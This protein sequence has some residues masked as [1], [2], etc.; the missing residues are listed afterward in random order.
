MSAPRCREGIRALASGW[1]PYG[2]NPWAR[3][4]SLWGRMKSSFLGLPL[5]VRLLLVVQAALYLAV[6]LAGRLPGEE[7]VTL[8]ASAVTSGRVWTLLTHMP[9]HFRSDA[10]GFLFD[11]SVLWSLGGIFGRRWRQTHFLF[12]YGTAGVVGGLAHVGAGLLW[13]AGCGVPYL[14][15]EA[16]SFAL[17]TAF[18]VVFGETPVSMFG[19]PPFK[20]KWVFFGL[21]A[22][23]VVLFVSG[24]NP[25]FFVQAGGTLGG[26]LM[27]TGRWRPGKLRAWLDG[28]ARKRE[29][30]RFRVLH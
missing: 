12:F 17:L 13:P 5:V 27:L 1:T 8:S 18:W 2:P 3:R 23:E 16:S 10:F 6:V 24:N 15:S 9:F 22:L 28:L 7:Y 20:G 14:G 26:W 25:A 30:S 19:S 11:V 21:A 4:Q 29:R